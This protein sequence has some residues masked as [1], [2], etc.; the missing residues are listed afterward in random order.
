[1][2]PRKTPDSRIQRLNCPVTGSTC[3]AKPTNAAMQIGQA[4]KN[5]ANISHPV[6]YCYWRVYAIGL[7]IEWG[8]TANHCV[9]SYN[10]LA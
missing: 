8:K 3:R 5:T 6:T 4:M 10:N 1:M 2:A 7:R 9:G